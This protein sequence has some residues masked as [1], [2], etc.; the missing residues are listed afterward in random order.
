MFSL[1]TN[2]CA[3]EVISWMQTGTDAFVPHCHY[4]VKLHSSP[5][6]SPACAAAIAHRNHCFHLIVKTTPLIISV[7]T[8][9][10]NRCKKVL[11]DVKSHYVEPTKSHIYSQKLGS[12]VF[13][14]IFNSDFNKGKCNVPPLFN[15]FEVL[16]SSKEKAGLLAQ[17]LSENCSFNSSGHG[18]PDFPSL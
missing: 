1:S 15:G 4:Q 2:E 17:S 5:W 16:T 3:S 7:F 13:W 10:G 14:K 8:L 12:R 11:N 9:A 18:L 6:F